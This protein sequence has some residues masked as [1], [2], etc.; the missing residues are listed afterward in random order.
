MQ[1]ARIRARTGLLGLPGFKFHSI[2]HKIFGSFV[3]R[4]GVEAQHCCVSASLKKAAQKGGPISCAE[5]GATG[6]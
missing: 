6:A 3:S 4:E 5:Q 1:S 2:F